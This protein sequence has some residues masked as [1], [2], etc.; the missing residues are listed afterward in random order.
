MYLMGG[1][2]FDGDN[3]GRNQLP[4]YIDL[5]WGAGYKNDG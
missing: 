5:Y 4:G 3:T 2:T 1:D